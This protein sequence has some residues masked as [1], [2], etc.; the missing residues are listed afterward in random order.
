MTEPITAP[1]EKDIETFRQVAAFYGAQGGHKAASRMSP[2][3]RGER[4]RK[5]AAA[6][7]AK[8]DQ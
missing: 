3:A 5:A 8:N 2:E 6:R 1:D 4:A 7:W